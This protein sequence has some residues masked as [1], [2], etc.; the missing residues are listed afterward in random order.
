MNQYNNLN[1][2]LKCISKYSNETKEP[3][4]ST[5]LTCHIMKIF[6]LQKKKI[7]KKKQFTKRGFLN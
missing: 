4:N 7:F 1:F 6:I 3:Y 2:H 5:Q